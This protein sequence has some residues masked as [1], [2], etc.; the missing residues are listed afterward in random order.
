VAKAREES[1][2]QGRLSVAA[3]AAGGRTTAQKLP[4]ASM[5]GRD[6]ANWE[7]G[8]EYHSTVP[9]SASDESASSAEVGGAAVGLADDRPD[10]AEDMPRDLV[11]DEA[12]FAAHFAVNHVLASCSSLMT[13][14]A[15][16]SP[17]EER[18]SLISDKSSERVIGAQR[19]SSRSG[20]KMRVQS[21]F[22]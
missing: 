12:T 16:R 11:T 5:S 20:S 8:R 7:S 6:T 2:L 9:P 10:D 4:S 14:C 13:A 18:A 3:D 21:A 15:I 22:R 1:D 17:D 19:T